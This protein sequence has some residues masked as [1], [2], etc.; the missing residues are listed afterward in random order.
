VEP[1]PGP[2]QASWLIMQRM[3]VPITR[4]SILA[5]STALCVGLTTCC[6]FTR[7]RWRSNIAYASTPQLQGHL[8]K[9]LTTT[10]QMYSQYRSQITNGA[11]GDKGKCTGANALLEEALSIQ[12]AL[13]QDGMAADTLKILASAHGYLEMFDEARS[14]LKQALDLTRRC[15]G[16]ESAEDWL[17][18]TRKWSSFVK[19]RSRQSKHRCACTWTTC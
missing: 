4:S 18:A 16:E 9:T 11:K 6:R 13:S 15:H 10:G 8:S 7:R 1:R 14:T 5:S 17:H 12:R 19:S 2:Q 3:R